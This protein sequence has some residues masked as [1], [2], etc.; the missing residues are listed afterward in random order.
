MLKA[1][2]SASGKGPPS[3]RNSWNRPGAIPTPSAA[4]N[5][6]TPTAS[7]IVSPSASTGESSS[8]VVA[9]IDQPATGSACT[10]VSGVSVGSWMRTDTVLAVSLSLGTRNAITP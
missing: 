4:V 5:S 2:L 3:R 8:V 9:V 6:T 7:V 1:T 10:K